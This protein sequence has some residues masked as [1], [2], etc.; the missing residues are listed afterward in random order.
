MFNPLSSK[1]FG[2]L[3]QLTQFSE[4]LTLA[5]VR[6]MGGGGGGS[7]Y[8]YL[9]KNYALLYSVI[10]L[11]YDGLHQV[12]QINT[13]QLKFLLGEMGK[14]SRIWPKIVTPNALLYCKDLF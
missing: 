6:G 1:K 14:L 7:N 9:S 8:A 5:W 13:S 10:L 2:T 12:D 3:P 4:G 11:Y